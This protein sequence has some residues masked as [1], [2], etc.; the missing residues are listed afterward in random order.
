MRPFC[1]TE[2][3]MTTATLSRRHFLT[4]SAAVVAG[5]FVLPRRALARP[6]AAATF[7]KWQEIAPGFRVGITPT[8]DF[9]LI[10]GN[11]TLL[12]KNGAGVMIDTKQS[13]L[14]P[15]LL[16][17]AKGFTESITTVL[18]TH[19][20]FDHTG[21]NA[22]FSQAG[23]V[24]IAH[25][26][27]RERVAK[28]TA[29][30]T[31]GLD[32]RIAALEACPVDGAKE[33]AAD[34][35]AFKEGLTKLKPDAFTPEGKLEDGAKLDAAQ[36]AGHKTEVH[37]VAPGHTDNDIFFFF[38]DENILV[39][40]DLIFNNRHAFYDATASPSISGWVKSLGR[41][42]QLCNAKTVVVPGHGEVDTVE[43][44][45]RQIK[46]FE[47]VKAL[48]AKAIKDGKKREEIMQMVIPGYDA[49]GMKQAQPLVLAGAFDEQT[50][51]KSGPEPTKE[52]KKDK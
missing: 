31:S 25:P 37:H 26:R 10:G 18:N 36:S 11:A 19:H 51:D 8:D 48:V 32:Q 6:R 38:P 23:A 45:K 24:L 34:A 35:K 1:L 49:Y 42:V 41:I 27:C 30:Y 47:D 21:G 16:R 14:G 20:H 2:K 13:V 50:M 40:G 9:N 4:T 28:M 39:A 3:I 15:S 12:V 5:G 17:E 46:Y 22:A 7:Y 29:M 43:S 33:A 44:A 52:E